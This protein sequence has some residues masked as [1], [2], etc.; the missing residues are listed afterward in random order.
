MKIFWLALIVSLLLP[1]AYADDLTVGDIGT[2]GEEPTAICSADLDENGIPDTA[3]IGTVSKATTFGTSYSWTK[4]VQSVNAVTAVDLD[5]DGYMDEVVV[6]G[7]DIV[8]VASNGDELWRA[9]G[10]L[11]HSVLGADL[12]GDGYSD[13]VVV[14]CW[15]KVAAF[16]SSGESL[17]NYTDI[18]GNVKALALTKY[19]II[20]GAGKMVYAIKFDGDIKWGKAVSKTVIGLA[21]VDFEGTGTPDGVIVA[22][23]GDSKVSIEAF[24]MYGAK[25]DWSIAEQYHDETVKPKMFSVDKY[26]RGK[27]D[28]ALLNL[29]LG[30][31]WVSTTGS[32]QKIQINYPNALSPIDFDGDGILDDVIIGTR[33]SSDSRGKVYAYSGI[34][35]SIGSNNQSGADMITAVDYDFDGNADDAIAV[36]K[37]DKKVYF[38]ISQVTDTTTSTP[39]TTAPPTTTP[40]PTTTAP[41]TTT[42]A[43]TTTA[44]PTTGGIS[45]DLGADQSVVEGTEVTLTASATPRT[46][47]GI[48]VN[49]LWTESGN[50]LKTGAENTLT[51]VFEKGTHEVKVLVL[52]NAGATADD[53]VNITVTATGTGNASAGD[54]DSDGW[55]DELEVQ[56]GTD[57][58]NPDTDED[59]IIDS[60]DPNPLVP[61][62]KGSLLGGLSTPIKVVI[63]LVITGGVIIAI[64]V[65]REKILDMLWDRNQDWGE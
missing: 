35:Q 36:S 32:L 17:W 44:P 30:V 62:G 54:S 33:V 7:K 14:G 53:T 51:K 16:D 4:Q 34:G 19:Y 45:V 63:G 24:T 43:P 26:S 52:D 13:E 47:D 27:L 23:Y 28:Y 12:D 40:A 56:M 37:F 20:A 48:I 21:A 9:K 60:E 50:L 2:T 10:Y 11:G 46:S 58:D 22:G 41:P 5:S 8:A 39:T 6:A 61:G 64:I 59:G 65:I 3:V 38:I 55:K 25:K 29:D 15:N 42:P 31:Y 1:P 57:P 18:T 49:Y